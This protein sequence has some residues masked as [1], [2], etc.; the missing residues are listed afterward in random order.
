MNRR[1]VWIGASVVSWLLLLF[2]GVL[3]PLWERSLAGACSLCAAPAAVPGREDEAGFRR[4]G[5]PQP[6]EWRWSSHEAEQSFE[7]Y[8]GGS[9]N[10]K[11][12]HRTTFYL[13][14]LGGA[15]ARYP[16]LLERMRVHA[17][18]YFGVPARILDPI[19]MIDEA[20]ASARDQYNAT[21]IINVLADRHPADALAYM[22]ITEKDL[23]SEGLNFVF[24]EGSLHFRCGVYS[25][26]RL[27]TGDA[28]L[29]LRRSLG[30][31]CHEAGHILSIDHCSAWF[32]VMD[33]ANSLEESDRHPLHLCPV[34]LR[35]VLWNTGADREA[36]YRRLYD[37]YRGW[38]LK[39]ESDWVAHQLRLH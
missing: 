1:W 24:G 7:R 39:S 19:P 26:R 30:L 17:E 23:Y 4:L 20:Y 33:G 31:V 15:S 36:R 6:G 9:V 11:C 37:L 35:K 14:P 32:C 28:S 38:G 22:G 29:F 27:E 18:A 10:R 12:E 13:Q 8:I 34:D 16:E 25:L 5:P 3:R 21:R 2:F